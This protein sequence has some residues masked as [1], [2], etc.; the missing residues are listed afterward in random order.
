MHS[1]DEEYLKLD[2]VVDIYIYIYIYICH[3]AVA[4]REE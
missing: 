4:I 1:T 2:F 3:S